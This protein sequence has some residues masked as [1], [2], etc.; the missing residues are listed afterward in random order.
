MYSWIPSP[1]MPRGNS[2][3]FMWCMDVNGKSPFWMSVFICIQHL[4]YC[5][6]SCGC[7]SDMI[8]M[9]VPL[10]PLYD[11]RF[12]PSQTGRQTHSSENICRKGQTRE[13]VSKSLSAFFVYWF[14]FDLLLRFDI[15]HFKFSFCQFVRSCLPCFVFLQQSIY[16]MFSLFYVFLCFMCYFT[17]S[18]NL[19]SFVLMTHHDT[20]IW[21]N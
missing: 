5:M 17:F 19:F 11:F 3:Q 20:L 21:V 15:P 9:I 7:V 8:I 13:F 1:V 10:Q 18:F 6:F 4:D 12:R 16:S 14:F 2:Q